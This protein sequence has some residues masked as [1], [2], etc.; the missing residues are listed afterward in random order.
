MLISKEFFNIYSEELI[1]SN[2][3]ND[4]IFLDNFIKE[5]N[6]DVTILPD[7]YNFGRHK[8]RKK[9]KCIS[10][11]PYIL[12]FHLER[13]KHIHLAKKYASEE[14]KSIIGI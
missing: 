6:I 5:N 13:P 2:F 12:H 7:D 9:I 11:N 10:G 8:M 4:E 3:P 14:L 1:K